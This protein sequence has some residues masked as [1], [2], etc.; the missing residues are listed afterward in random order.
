VSREI[1]ERASTFQ[2]G[3]PERTEEKRLQ[4]CATFITEG[5]EISGKI[6]VTTL[7]I[8]DE[9]DVFPRVPGGPVSVLI[10]I[11]GHKSQ[12]DPMFLTYIN[13][14]NHIWKVCLGVPYATSHWQ[15]GDSAEQ[16]GTFGTEKKEDLSVKNVTR[17]CL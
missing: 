6:L 3:L 5:G 2:G 13:D 11:V 14:A 9:L 12:L 10:M 16:N 7:Q 1:L 15:V 8:L 17:P 4:P